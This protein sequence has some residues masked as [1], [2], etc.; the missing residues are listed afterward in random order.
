MILNMSLHGYYV[1]S[2]VLP[3]LPVHNFGPFFFGSLISSYIMDFNSVSAK[4]IANI[5]LQKW[6]TFYV[7]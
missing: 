1:K 3:L 4:Y 2:L 6:L 7:V 5:F